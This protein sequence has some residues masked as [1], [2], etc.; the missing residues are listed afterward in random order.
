[1]GVQSLTN[2]F[3][4]TIRARV[5]EI[6]TVEFFNGVPLLTND[7]LAIDYILPLV[8]Q[9]DEKY[10]IHLVARVAYLHEGITQHTVVKA[11]L[12]FCAQ[13][14]TDR[15]NWPTHTEA[16]AYPLVASL[17]NAMSTLECARLRLLQ[18]GE[19]NGSSHN[20]KRIWV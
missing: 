19:M 4:E 8:W 12:F 16:I 2:N 6:A 9:A 17:K 20:M 1:M 14:V 13:Q 10:D 7:K 18:K 3:V 11:K 5:K 15:I